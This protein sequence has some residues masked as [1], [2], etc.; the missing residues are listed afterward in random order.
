M[1]TP[2]KTR[3]E[4]EI[5]LSKLTDTLVRDSQ[6]GE[7]FRRHIDSIMSMQSEVERL[8]H[9]A[10]L[11]GNIYY[12]GNFKAETGNERELESLLIASGFRYKTQDEVMKAR[13]KYPYEKARQPK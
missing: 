11:I 4:W 7:E 13:E 5:E 10:F 9:I 2:P 6:W 8:R 12:Y 3:E 1:T